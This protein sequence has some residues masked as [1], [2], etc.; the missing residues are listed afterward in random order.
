MSEF[1]PFPIA[2]WATIVCASRTVVGL[3]EPEA[4]SR[5]ISPPVLPD[6][7]LSVSAAL[8]T[9]VECSTSS[10]EFCT[11]R[12]PPWPVAKLVEM[13]LL[14]MR[15]LPELRNIIAPP[16]AAVLYAKVL[17]ERVTPSSPSK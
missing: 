15:E 6:P 9:M 3:I 14:T 4:G 13:V 10:G 1:V 16:S 7:S 17:A 2:F 8:R 11:F 5:T 12:P